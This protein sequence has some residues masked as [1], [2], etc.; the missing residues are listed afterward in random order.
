MAAL[1]LA[2]TS[3]G[4]LMVSA[5]MALTSSALMGSMAI[6]SFATSRLLITV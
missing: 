4:A 1:A 2:T 5:T 6:C 3:G